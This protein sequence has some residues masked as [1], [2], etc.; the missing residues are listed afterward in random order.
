MS[1]GRLGNL[2]GDL[3]IIQGTVYFVAVEAASQKY[4]FMQKK[5]T[6]ALSAKDTSLVDR[7]I[8]SGG[9]LT[10]ADLGEIPALKALET[11]NTSVREI[12]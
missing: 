7:F 12:N 11:V 5:T 8:A 2:Q 6:T 1:H 4:L 9:I 3:Q 10:K